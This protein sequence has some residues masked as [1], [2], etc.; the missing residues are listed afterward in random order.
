LLGGDSAGGNLALGVLAHVI[1][2]H[3]DVPLIARGEAGGEKRFKGVFVLSPWQ[4]H[5]F[6]LIISLG[7]DDRAD[8]K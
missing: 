8:Y 7:E 2:P 3:P 5:P 6:I 1:K 4:V